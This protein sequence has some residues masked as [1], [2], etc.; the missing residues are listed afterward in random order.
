MQHVKRRCRIGLSKELYVP[1]CG[2]SGGL[3]LWWDESIDLDILYSSKN[4]IHDKLRG[5]AVRNG[6]SWL[7]VGDFNDLLYH[8]EKW[9]RRP[10]ASRKILS[11][12]NLLNDCDLFDLD[13]KGLEFTWTNNMLRKSWIGPWVILILR[14]VSPRPKCRLGKRLGRTI[15]LWWW[16]FV[17]KMRE[18][19]KDSRDSADQIIKR[20]KNCS[21]ALTKWSKKVFPNNRV[22]IE[23]LMEQLNQYNVRDLTET[24]AEKAEEIVKAMEEAWDRE[25]QFWLQRAKVDSL[26]RGDQ[27]SKFLHA[28]VV[29]RR[30]INKVLK[31][32]RS[33]GSWIEGEDEIVRN[34]GG[35]YENLFYSSRVR[36]FVE[37]MRYVHSVIDD[38]ENRLL[39]APITK[40][41]LKPRNPSRNGLQASKVVR[42]CDPGGATTTGP[43][44]YSGAF[45]RRA[46]DEVGD[47]L[48]EMVSEFMDKGVDL[49][50]LN[51]TKSCRDLLK[52]GLVWRIG[53]GVSV[54]VWKD[55]WVP[56]IKGCKLSQGLHFADSSHLMVADLIVGGRWDLSFI[57]DFITDEE[58][59]AIRAIPLSRGVVPDRLIWGDVRNGMYKVNSGY[60]VAK[61][62]RI[63]VSC[64]KP[65]CS[66]VVSSQCPICNSAPETIEHMLM[67]CDWV[68]LV[69]FVSP[70][71]FKLN[72][73]N[74]KRFEDWCEEVLVSNK[75]IDDFGRSV[76]AYLCCECW[77]ARCDVVFKGVKVDIVGVVKRALKAVNEFWRV[78]CGLGVIFRNEKG[79]VIDGWCE[80]FEAGS[81]LM[82]EAKALLKA[83]QMVIDRG[84]SGV[85]FETDCVVLAQMIDRRDLLNCDWNCFVLF[86]DILSLWN[87]LVDCRICSVPRLSNQVANCLA[88]EASRRVV[89]LD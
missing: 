12:Q 51:F 15:V 38:D 47:K 21:D 28:S 84:W 32:K 53:N 13:E 45:F 24:I 10:R 71:G 77:M 69:G 86:S 56:G 22:L 57:K 9:G 50:D 70:L 41:E 58:E 2:L 35:F 59:A 68:N 14:V 39:C 79:R 23:K 43:D 33:D 75:G 87:S 76:W 8:G 20:L 30:R 26:K 17:I 62:W 78:G 54:D 27:N 18:E 36:N 49:R 80:G 29:Q 52:K 37:A 74:T 85:V 1:T 88:K 4:L 6:A 81:S 60:R 44:G 25:E 42:G 64:D 16:I 89:P 48:T 11:F 82:T 31:L 63:G 19:V 65:S 73:M 40:L 66:S 5:L 3:A 55:S 46:L 67:L 83:M 72:D 7:C 34:F 61:S